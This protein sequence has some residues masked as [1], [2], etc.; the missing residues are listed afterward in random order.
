MVESALR[1]SR[2]HILKIHS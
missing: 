1:L 2:E